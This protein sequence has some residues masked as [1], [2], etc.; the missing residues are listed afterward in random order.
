M[1]HADK[2]DPSTVEYAARALDTTVQQRAKNANRAAVAYALELVA[3]GHEELSALSPPAIRD[4]I[5]RA[6]EDATAAH[7]HGW[8]LFTASITSLF[9]ELDYTGQ[10]PTTDEYA[11]HLFSTACALNAR[12]LQNP[13]TAA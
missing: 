12:P 11:R 4:L 10:L 2:I 1:N 9:D 7:V 5:R 6:I 8:M 3:N 13:E